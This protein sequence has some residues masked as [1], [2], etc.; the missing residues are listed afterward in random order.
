M[1][2]VP[3]RMVGVS[4]ILL[5]GNE[6]TPSARHIFTVDVDPKPGGSDPREPE[7]FRRDF[8]PYVR[9]RMEWFGIHTL[10][11]FRTLKGLHLISPC[12]ADLRTVKRFQSDFLRWGGD[13]GHGLMT[14]R[15]GQ[16]IIRV[17]AKPGEGEGPRLIRSVHLDGDRAWS[18]PHFDF[19]AMHREGVRP[20]KN[21]GARVE[22]NGEVRLE[23]YDTT[24]MKTEQT[25]LGGA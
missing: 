17:T 2:E 14:W 24:A 1:N 21:L 10:W 18:G 22:A 9:D 3:C 6:A 13:D 12:L 25:I 7:V 4:S 11:V 23:S 5:D 20:P 15:N 19:F 8:M 16:S